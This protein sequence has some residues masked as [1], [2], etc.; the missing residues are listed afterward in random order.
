MYRM[1]VGLAKY[2]M[3]KYHLPAD[4]K[5]SERAKLVN[6]T[7][8]GWG[9]AKKLVEYQ[10]LSSEIKGLFSSSRSK[11]DLFHRRLRR[12]FNYNAHIVVLPHFGGHE[13]RRSFPSTIRRQ[14]GIISH[15][16]FRKLMEE[17][18][19]RPFIRSHVYGHGTLVIAG[20]EQFTTKTCSCR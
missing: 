2:H 10:E 7:P 15:Y 11:I 5:I 16:K 4:I 17:S 9:A 18:S 19:F 3:R 13:Q 8:G 14:A 12:W 6:E 1:G 20:N